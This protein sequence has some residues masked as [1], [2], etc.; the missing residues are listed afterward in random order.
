MKK[1]LTKILGI[2]AGIAMAVGVGAGIALSNNQKVTQLNAVSDLTQYSLIN[3]TSDLEAG[4]SYIITSGMSSTVKA[5]ATDS[6][7]NN[8]KT[9]NVTVDDGKITR[10]SSVMSFTLGGTSGAWT[11]AT[12]NYSGDAG[13][14]A[15][16]A[17]GS[18]NYLRVIATA[19]TATI[20][21]SS[22]EAVINIGPHESRTQIRYNSGSNLFACYSSGQSAVYLW[23]EIESGEEP[24]DSV[25]ISIS[26]TTLLLNI[27]GSATHSLTATAF[28]TGNAT[29]GL[30][31]VSD[32]PSVASVSNAT[33]T[34]GVAFTVTAEGAGIA[35]IT[36]A[37]SWNAEVTASCTV[38]VIDTTPR[39]V[40]FKKVNSLSSGQKV[41]ITTVIDGDYYY[42]PSTTTNSN[43]AK[44]A[45]T[46]NST[47][48]MITG[49]DANMAFSVSGDS[50]GWEFTNAYGD[51]LKIPSN[52]TNVRVNSGA[53][54]FT[55]TETTNGFYLQSTT[56]TNRYL[57]AYV[58][59]SD[60]RA[61]TSRTEN[62][63]KGTDNEYNCDWINF[64]V[65]A[66][67]IQIISGSSSAFTDQTVALSSNAT[68]PTWSIV[69]GDT[70]AEGAAVTAAGVVSAAGAGSV[71]VKA[72]HDDYEDAYFTITFTVRP[73]NPFIT[74]GKP[75]TSGFSGQNETVSFTYDHLTGE[76]SVVSDDTEVVTV[77]NLSASAGS[78]TVKLNFIG[79][80]TT[81][82]KFYDGGNHL[83]TIEVSV[84]TSTVTI[85]GLPAN[86]SICL[87]ETL[88]LGSLISV[89]A[90]G[91][92]SSDVTW[93]S[94]NEAVAT[95]D[96][97]GVVT[98]AA[99]GSTDII[100]T[101]DDYSGGA[102]TCTV[103]VS[104]SSFKLV[105]SL[106]NGKKYII[107]A[108]G[109]ANPSELYYLPAANE[110]IPSNPAAVK[111]NTFAALT[112]DNAWTASIDGSG[113]IVFSNQIEE[114]T[115]YLTA[116]NKAQGISVSTTNNGYWTLDATGLTYSDAGSRYLA[117]FNDGS[118][119]YYGAPLESGQ[120][121]AN[122]F[123]EF[124]PAARGV[125][126]E[127]D[128]LSSL[129]YSEYTKVSE[130]NFTFDDLSIRFGGFI[131]QDLW[132][133]LDDEL[134]IQGYGVIL[135]TG[136]EEIEDLYAAAKDEEDTVEQALA[137]F[138]NNT[139]IKRFYSGL[140]LSKTH[141]TEATSAQKTYM[142]VDTEET[143][144]VW[145]LNKSISSEYMTTVYNVV[146]YIIVDGD[147]VFLNAAKESTKTL[148][149][150][151]IDAE[152]GKYEESDFGGSL[153]Y[154]AD[155]SV[156][157]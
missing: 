50:D 61:Y 35:H 86:R 31:A 131:S 37:S 16:A 132:E 112:E 156:L 42:L 103:T 41:L 109:S 51:Y 9:T 141:P 4:K 95:V 6:N 78:G 66:K 128:T 2:T 27:N 108:Q 73:T 124:V 29:A 40:N 8:R 44:T 13:Y 48:Q 149:S 107:A 81:D 10:G 72:V 5:I 113:H 88:D 38:T 93:S 139:T 143:Y 110:A 49:V 97:S 91:S 142:G 90:T 150:G 79:G 146:A 46:Y 100:V 74:P 133:R 85:T 117:T 56:Y 119:R 102:E 47:H 114:S 130:D 19:G 11:F 155:L 7:N 32:D 33:P 69:A 43:P 116:T 12:E 121:M 30:T 137:E 104:K 135:S 60:W 153:K 28:T 151:L 53:H 106:Q 123:Y 36:V 82:V 127:I 62:N 64:W 3:D 20:S 96:E 89:T 45:C 25:S 39:M 84:I 22:D 17:S 68:S 144:Y 99:K 34:S 94:S 125:I 58:S 98:A 77:S 157:P 80:G 145:T 21:F 87:G 15:S 154:L 24:V 126:S 111:I 122:V 92:C 65:E 23:K 129:C 52:G 70:T 83:A 120:S 55:A 57:G 1:L 105:D 148:A 18:N 14:L 101:P 75:S 115:Y 76:L 59:G 147:I 67:T 136:N 63:Y 26:N 54:A 152:H 71:K 140:S 134:D 138:V 118:F